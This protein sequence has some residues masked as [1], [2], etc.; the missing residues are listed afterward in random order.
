VRAFSNS[1][2]E[3]ILEFPVAQIFDMVVAEERRISLRRIS[4]PLLCW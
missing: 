1:D 2:P 4:L 3:F